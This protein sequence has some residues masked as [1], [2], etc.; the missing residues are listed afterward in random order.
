MEYNNLMV[1]DYDQALDAY[2]ALWH[3]LHIYAPCAAC[4]GR[5]TARAACTAHLVQEGPLALECWQ[6]LLL[7]VAGLGDSVQILWQERGPELDP[8]ALLLP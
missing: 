7:Q 2:G 1:Y 5:E 8:Q 4:A 6:Q 3:V